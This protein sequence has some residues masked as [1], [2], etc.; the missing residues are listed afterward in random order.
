MLIWGPGYLSW[1]SDSL[2]A[3]RS[4][5]R[6]LVG[7]EILRTRPDLPWGSPSLLYNGYRLSFPE[8]KRPER[9]VDHP[10]FSAVV[11]ETV[12]LY[13]SSPSGRSWPVNG[14]LYLCQFAG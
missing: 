9:D 14:E 10:P 4:R 6:T 12:D 2:R 1:Y 5:D 7:G 13:L 8:V 11:K 3:G